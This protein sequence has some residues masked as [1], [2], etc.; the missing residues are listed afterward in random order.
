ML[1]PFLFAALAVA[2]LLAG[3]SSEGGTPITSP[4]DAARP[5]PPPGRR[6]T[7]DGGKP[8]RGTYSRTC[9]TNGDCVLVSFADSACDTCKCPNDAIAVEEQRRFYNE[10]QAFRDTCTE[11][12]EPCL[13][14]CSPVAARCIDRLCKAVVTGS[15]PPPP[16]D[17]S[18]RDG[19]PVDGSDF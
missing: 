7:G 4:T 9:T 18:V 1:R 15:P 10:E 5:P 8:N 2:S 12:P 11:T 13:A 3:C 14:D 17:A 16:P 6:P 19:G